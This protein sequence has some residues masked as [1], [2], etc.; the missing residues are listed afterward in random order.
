MANNKTK[1]ILT[2][3]LFSK[4]IV[5]RNLNSFWLLAKILPRNFVKDWS[6][7]FYYK[8]YVEVNSYARLTFKDEYCASRI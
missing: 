5:I 8:F 2:L 3:N 7:S 6:Q 4:R 1:L